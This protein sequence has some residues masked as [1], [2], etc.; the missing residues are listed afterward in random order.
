MRL[1]TYRKFSHLL[2]LGGSGT[3]KAVVHDITSF[4]RREMHNKDSMHAKRLR[5]LVLRSSDYSFFQ[6]VE[7]RSSHVGSTKWLYIFFGY[8][9]LFKP[10][11]FNIGNYVDK[12]IEIYLATK[13]S[14]LF[15]TV[16]GDL[17]LDDRDI[18]S[19]EILKEYF[20]KVEIRNDLLYP[21]EKRY[22]TLNQTADFHIELPPLPKLH[23][24]HLL[25]KALMHKEAYRALLRPE[26]EVA[27]KL[28]ENGWDLNYRSYTIFRYELSFLDGLGDFYLA[29]ESS[30]LLY[31]FYKVGDKIHSHVYQLLKVILLTNTVLSQMS[32]AYNMHKGLEDPVLNKVIHNEYIPYKTSGNIAHWMGD[33]K[34]ARV[35]EE[36]FLGDYFESYVGALFLEQPEVAE[37]FVGEIYANILHLIT[38]TLPPDITYESYCVKVMGRLLMFK[39]KKA[40]GET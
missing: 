22:I 32:L 33:F 35:F 24:K 28:Q 9:Q 12:I 7:R 30:K 3:I 1:E 27:A 15:Y 20:D 6:D 5:D 19:L 29:R 18:E 23:S 13:E 11:D 39:K 2:F 16:S 37:R 4:I 10:E 31:E 8:L 25:V 34:E 21:E 40:E 36:E 17:L 14:P 26:H 38:Q